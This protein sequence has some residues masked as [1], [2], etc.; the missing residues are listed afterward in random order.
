VESWSRS[1]IAIFV[2]V[3]AITVLVLALVAGMI[4]DR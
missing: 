1:A 2:A 3:A 4:G